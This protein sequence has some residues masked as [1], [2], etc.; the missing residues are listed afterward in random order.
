M[1]GPGMS[2]RGVLKSEGQAHWRKEVQGAQSHI[3][4]GTIYLSM[5]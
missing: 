1:H 2:S 3:A 4:R 5:C